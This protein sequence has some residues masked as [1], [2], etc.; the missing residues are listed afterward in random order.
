MKDCGG[1]TAR[2]SRLATTTREEKIFRIEGV[3]R[4]MWQLKLKKQ[5]KAASRHRQKT[6][7]QQWGG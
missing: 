1:M 6:S 2:I 3:A 5:P 7:V 4:G